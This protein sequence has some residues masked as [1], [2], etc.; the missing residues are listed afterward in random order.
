MLRLYFQTWTSNTCMLVQVMLP[1]MFY[2]LSIPYSLSWTFLRGQQHFSGCYFWYHLSCF[3]S[4]QDTKTIFHFLMVLHI[5]LPR[6]VTHTCTLP[7]SYSC[8]RTEFGSSLELTPIE[9]SIAVKS[10]FHCQ[11]MSGIQIF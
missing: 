1:I 4:W 7:S 11:S 5:L 3:L 6:I 10:L 9:D 8:S 2:T